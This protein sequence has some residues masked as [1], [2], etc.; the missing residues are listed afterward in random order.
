MA[1]GLEARVPL[2]DHRVVE[3]A[4]RIPTEL[5]HRD[6]KGKWLLRKVL[7][8]YVPPELMDRPKMGFGVPIEHW[9]RGPLREWG[10]ELLDERRL[11]EEGFFDPE[12]I[13]RMW[14]EHVTGKRR[15]H[16]L[17]WTVLM[18][19]AWHQEWSGG[20]IND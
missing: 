11:R 20:F 7:D 18:F 16:A 8:R 19:Q 13:R 2:L 10:E 15:W 14:Q 17:L 5:K 4:W 12:P 1:V 6:G 9:L 3:L